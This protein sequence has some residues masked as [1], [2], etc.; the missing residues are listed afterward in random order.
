MR[1]MQAQAVEL[2]SELVAIESVNPSL[3]PGGAGEG[4]IAAFVTSWSRAAGLDAQVLEETPG[5]PSV[6]VRARGTGE[7]RTL[8]LCGHL[9][10]VTTAGMSE[11][12]TPRVDGDRHGRGAYDMKAGV[13][14]ALLACREAASL[15]SR[16]LIALAARL[17]A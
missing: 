10:T 13:A 11:P 15:G 8:L 9:D 5:R 6:V 16:A 12:L 7:G 3:V 17:C 4:E 14:A 1:R 2:L